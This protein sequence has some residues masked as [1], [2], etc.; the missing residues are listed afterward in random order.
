MPWALALLQK[1]VSHAWKIKCMP[2]SDNHKQKSHMKNFQVFKCRPLM[3][4]DCYTYSFDQT[5]GDKQ[6]RK[7]QKIT[8]NKIGWKI[9]KHHPPLRHDADFNWLKS[10]DNTNWIGI[11]ICLFIQRRNKK[12]MT[13]ILQEAFETRPTGSVEFEESIGHQS[14]TSCQN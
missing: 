11:N 14:V 2:T 1:Y 10:N 9:H 4:L 7:P 13:R 8:S 3:N 5:L 6:R 12:M